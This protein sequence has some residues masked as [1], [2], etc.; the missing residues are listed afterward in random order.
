MGEI[1]VAVQAAP[2]PRKSWA[3]T[4]ASIEA[5]D[6]GAG[7]AFLQ[8]PPGIARQEHLLHVLLWLYET[9]RPWCLRLEDDTLVNA[10]IA[11]NI[12]RWEGLPRLLEGAGAI[13]WLYAPVGVLGS[14]P[15]SV[16]EP[17]KWQRFL[18]GSLGI[19]VARDRVPAL[20]V[21]VRAVYGRHPNVCQDVL[22]CRA[23]KQA[24]LRILLH[25]PPLVEHQWWT[26]STL[27][28]APYT[29][30]RST[31]GRWSETWRGD[32]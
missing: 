20:M 21:A 30:A 10:H 13:G 25:D 19:L 7:Y 17:P 14:A 18:P 11:E 12:L 22:L 3:A 31:L 16:K 8:S 28:P 9:G 32:A 29:N 26:P 5:S 6:I 15:G 4:R 23:A 27:Q 24:G 1:A 2:W